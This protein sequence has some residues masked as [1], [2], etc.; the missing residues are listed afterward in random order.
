MHYCC[1][2]GPSV[3]TVVNTTLHAECKAY[4]KCARAIFE[5][6]SDQEGKGGEMQDAYVEAFLTWNDRDSFQSSENSESSQG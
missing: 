5:K 1:I 3:Y 2:F 6:A 4:Q